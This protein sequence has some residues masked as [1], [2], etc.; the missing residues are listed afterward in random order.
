M[1]EMD[2][3]LR[4]FGTVFSHS[5]RAGREI[6]EFLMSFRNTNSNG[7]NAAEKIIGDDYPKK[8]LDNFVFTGKETDLCYFNNSDKLPLSAIANIDDETL[9]KKVVDN[10]DRLNYKGMIS[11]DGQSISLTEKGKEILADKSFQ[12]RAAADQQ[13]AFNEMMFPKSESTQMCTQLTGDT[14]NDFTLFNLTDK[15]DLS[16]IAGSPNA[17]LSKK[18]LGNVKIWKDLGLVDV[19]DNMAF[20]TEKGKDYLMNP[21]FKA[22]SV[23]LPEKALSAVKAVSGKIIVA[24]KVVASQA[25]QVMQ[26]GMSLGK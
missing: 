11:F 16:V 9:K 23:Q 24:T 21:K 14:L 25:V 10:F 12:K 20:I 15:L 8:E 26:K 18:V 7:N 4:E 2:E 1:D 3:S 17:E 13:K 5:A 19:K 22:V 6:T